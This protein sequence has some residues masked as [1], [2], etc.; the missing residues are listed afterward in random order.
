MLPKKS[1]PSYDSGDERKVKS[2]LA[3][4]SEFLFTSLFRMPR[5]RGHVNSGFSYSQEASV[6]E[7]QKMQ[8]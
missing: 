2:P 4:G 8:C 5:P 3:A 7:I 1:I 6:P